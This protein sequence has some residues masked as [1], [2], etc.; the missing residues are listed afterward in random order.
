MKNEKSLKDFRRVLDTLRGRHWDN[1]AKICKTI[2]EIAH[3]V[4]E[5]YYIREN[6]KI[7][8]PIDIR[9]IVKSY[10]IKITEVY[11]NLDTGFQIERINGRIVYSDHG[12]CEITQRSTVN[13]NVKRYMLA[14]EFAHFLMGDKEKKNC[15]DPLFPKNCEELIADIMAAYLLFPYELVLL[16]MKSYVEYMK[17][18]NIYPIDSVSWL[19]ALGDS[20]QVSSYHTIM[21]YQWVRM[22]LYSLYKYKDPFVTSEQ[23]QQLFK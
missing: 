1:E 7:T 2:N 23:F 5:A 20:A 11:L 22:H 9:G 3:Q 15:I 6:R 12:E 17:R 19:K 4:I 10:G 16:K 8:F 14:H 18:G 21:C 13:E